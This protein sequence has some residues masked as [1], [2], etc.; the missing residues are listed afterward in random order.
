MPNFGVFRHDLKPEGRPHYYIQ[1]K[2][3]RDLVAR[4]LAREVNSYSIQLTTEPECSYGLMSG[5]GR[6]Y[7]AA[8]IE[9]VIKPHLIGGLTR[10]ETQPAPFD[11][12]KAARVG[13]Q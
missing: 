9:T 12:F 3:A 10:T 13:H 6:I 5:Q 1:R 8:A 11:K 7:E 4:G 2:M